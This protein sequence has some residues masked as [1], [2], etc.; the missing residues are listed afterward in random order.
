MSDELTKL[1]S[2]TTLLMGLFEEVKQL[3]LLIS[4]KDKKIDELE[5]KVNELEQNARQ[6]NIVLTGL[7]V[8]PR[9]Y[10]KA[11]TGSETTEDAPQEEL[12]TLEKQVVTFLKDK[13]I[14]VDHKDIS[15][16]YTLPT[17]MDKSKPAIVVRFTSRKVRN[18]VLMQARKLTG[19]KVYIN[20]HLT[21]KNSNIAREARLL[22]KQKKIE[23]TWTRNG[24][25]WIKVKEGSQATIIKELKDL[26]RFR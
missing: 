1:T 2:Q 18:N 13:D 8:K 7:E 6:E 16:C 12:L 10:K 20:E 26:D 5:Q 23:S 21:K 11:L 15:I 9:S 25:I 4:N 22:R 19:S 24:N 3:K 14:G 17:K